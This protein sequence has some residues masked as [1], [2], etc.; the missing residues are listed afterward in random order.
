MVTTS[1]FYCATVSGR[2]VPSCQAVKVP[3]EATFLTSTC[4]G[5]RRPQP[6]SHPHVTLVVPD[7]QQR[8]LRPVLGL[9]WWGGWE[10]C[11]G[12]VHLRGTTLD[13]RW[14][15][16][17]RK[18][19]ARTDLVEGQRTCACDDLDLW[20]LLPKQ[21]QGKKTTEGDRRTPEGGLAS[22]ARQA[23]DMTAAGE[24]GGE[25]GEGEMFSEKYQLLTFFVCVS[26]NKLCKDGLWS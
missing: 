8:E 3:V 21:V 13:L 17:L 10:S 24:G 25:R 7:Q 15:I 20:L 22:H 4:P 16:L 18:S 26:G 12:I 23:R 6:D 14:T 2:D 1:E 19:Q 5:R 9:C 11:R